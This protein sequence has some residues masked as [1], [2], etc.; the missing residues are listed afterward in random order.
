MSGATIN[1][2]SNSRSPKSSISQ[3]IRATVAQIQQ[4]TSS[5]SPQTFDG[6]IKFRCYFD[7]KEETIDNKGNV[8]LTSVSR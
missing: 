8:S 6:L 2:S 5:N 7:I 4:Q 1:H 3:A